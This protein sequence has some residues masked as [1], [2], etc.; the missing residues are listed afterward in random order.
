MKTVF[1]IGDSISLHYHQYIKELLE[2]KAEY[3]RKG[4]TG[5]IQEAL[6]D[7]NNPFGANGGDSNLVIEYMEML[8][9]KNKK[10]DILIINCGLHDIRVDRRNNK[11]QLDEKQYEENLNKII[12]LSKEISKQLIWISITPVN[13]EIHNSRNDGYLRYN[14]DVKKY[15]EIA[16]NIM[17][18]NNIKIIDL[19]EFTQ[20]LE[21]QDM[22]RDHVHYKEDICEKQ[23]QFIYDNIKQL[24]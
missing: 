11:I 12:E 15:N 24:L 23:A 16:E 8:K 5:E 7:P 10:F 3:Y 4:S 1:I 19:Y 13:D 18:E 17:S 14:K 20:N 2:N 22:Y 6:H 21:S 9:S